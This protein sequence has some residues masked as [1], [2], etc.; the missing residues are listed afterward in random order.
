MHISVLVTKLRK[1]YK[2]HQG[3]SLN[4]IKMEHP[5]GL[6]HG[7]ASAAAGVSAVNARYSLCYVADHKLC[8]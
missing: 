7:S 5:Y 2:L 3:S 6:V 1:V 4:P 8:C